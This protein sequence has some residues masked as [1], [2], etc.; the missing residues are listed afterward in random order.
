MEPDLAASRVT[1]SICV[2]A[3]SS[4]VLPSKKVTT[5]VELSPACTMSPGLSWV[6]T[7]PGTGEMDPRFVSRMLPD[8]TDSIVRDWSVPEQPGTTRSIATRARTFARQTQP[9][10]DHFQFFL[11]R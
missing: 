6:P 2:P 9:P 3:F 7:P 5:A 10:Y 11:I 1:I 4:M 8:A